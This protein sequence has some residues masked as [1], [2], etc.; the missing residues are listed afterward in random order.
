MTL[1]SDAYGADMRLVAVMQYLR[2]VFVVLAAALVASYLG[3]SGV[4]AHQMDW[5]GVTSW[6][7][8][9]AT[10]LLVCVCVAFGWHSRIPSGALLVPMLIG[11]LIKSTGLMPLVL[12]HWLLAIAYMMLGWGIGFR[13][14][15]AA[16]AHSARLLPYITAA[17]LALLLANAGIAAVLMYWAD[18]DYL[19]TFW[20]PVPAEPTP[21]RL[22]RR[23][24]TPIY[25][26]SWQC[27]SH[28][29]CW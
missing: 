10:L 23:R 27:R 15:P 12:P 26:S 17:I 24:H 1:M 5:L 2:M 7:G 25:R 14:T 4:P 21:L 18:I 13:F 6:P 19:S 11:L 8:F 28:A 22:S 3:A 29:F 20:Q 9:G 16:L